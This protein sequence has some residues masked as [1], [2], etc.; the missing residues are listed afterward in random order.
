MQRLFSTLAQRAV[1]FSLIT[2]VPTESSVL[3]S[4][5]GKEVVLMRE[6]FYKALTGYK[7][8]MLQAK[9]MVVLGLITPAEYSV[10]ETKMCER[11]GINFDSLYRENDWIN[12]DFRGNM[13]PVKEVL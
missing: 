4:A 6:D 7:S 9:R 10:I 5:T 8:A 3:K 11:F 1:R 13:S 2:A 12:T